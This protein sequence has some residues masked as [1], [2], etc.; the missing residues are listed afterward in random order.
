MASYLFLIDPG[1]TLFAGP[2]QVEPADVNGGL[3]RRDL[4]CPGQYSN[5]Q[6]SGAH[7][8]WTSAQVF[9]QLPDILVFAAAVGTSGIMTG[10][11]AFLKSE[12]PSLVNSVVFTV[13]GDCLAC[14]APDQ[15]TRSNQSTFH[16]ANPDLCPMGPLGGPSSD[17]AYFGLLKYLRHQKEAGAFIVCNLPYQCIGEYVSK[18]GGDAFP[19]VHH[20]EI[21]DVDL[22]PYGVDSEST[23]AKE[24]TSAKLL[25]LVAQDA[26]SIPTP[27]LT[28]SAPASPT[29]TFDDRVLFAVPKKRRLQEKCM[30]MLKSSGLQFSKPNRLDI[31][32]VNNMPITLV[33]FPAADI[34]R[35]VGESSVDMGM[36]GQ[37]VILE[38]KMQ[39]LTTESLSLGF[40]RC[41]LQVQVPLSNGTEQVEELAGKKIATSF[42]S[43]AGNYFGEID[44][45]LGTKTVVE[46]LSGSVETACALGLADGIGK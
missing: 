29:N 37:D 10:T 23:G 31:C 9:A 38:S 46:Y 14:L 27:P 19:E 41:K 5:P 42:E 13:P 26:A 16:R 32:I 17:L 8:R 34:P 43:V 18:L 25:K 35:F 21:L 7:I 36:T 40:G 6:D 28:E 44:A 2:A 20:S 12:R 4:Y 1:L 24:L 33:F 22:Y 11:G 45:R 3:G 15:L 39:S 30:E